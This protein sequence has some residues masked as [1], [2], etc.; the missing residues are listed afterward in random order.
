MQEQDRDLIARACQQTTEQNILITH[1]TDTMVETA[2]RLAQ[3]AS[4]QTIVLLGAMIPYRI[5][6]S[7]ALFNLGAAMAAVQCL[8]AGVYIAMSGRVF[9]WDEV[10]KDRGA[11]V[12][13][14]A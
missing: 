1:G 4:S 6:H 8:S 2:Q 3:L 14:E 7:D 9:P 13:V 5:D 10:V 12:F 11:A